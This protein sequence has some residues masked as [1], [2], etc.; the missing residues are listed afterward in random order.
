MLF[1]FTMNMPSYQRNLVHQVIGEHSAQ[2][3]DEMCDCL[4][5]QD[6]IIVNQFYSQETSAGRSLIAKGR[7]ILNTAMIGKII[8][9]KPT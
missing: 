6:Y 9:Y 8:E 7:V 3:L 2:S 5:L 1:T 4:T